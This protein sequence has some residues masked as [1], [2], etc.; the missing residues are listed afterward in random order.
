MLAILG[1]VIYSNTFNAS[2]VFDDH[3]MIERNSTIRHLDLFTLWQAF[4]T[5]FVVGLSL[6]LNYWLG[7]ENVVGY[8][9]F[10]LVVHI[11]NSFLVYQLLGL[12]FQTPR[13]IKSSPY[14]R[15]IGFLTALIFLTHP[16]QTQGVTYIWQRAT[17]LAAFF[18]L[19]ALVFYIRARIK[20]SRLNYGS[21]LVF[22]VLGMLTKE[23]VFTLPFAIL[24][25][26]FIFLD[27]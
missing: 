9:L 13:L 12:T 24:L 25:Y 19:G 2:F 4:N 16:L 21:C 8:H 5:R 26:E 10:N 6:A 18:Y 1:F 22:A 15:L 27:S 23:N 3:A 14:P 11:L 7:K 17:S 20:S